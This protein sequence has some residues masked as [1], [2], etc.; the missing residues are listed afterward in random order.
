MITKEKVLEAQK[1]W[2]DGIIEIGKGNREASEFVRKMYV[3]QALFKPTMAKKE[4]FRI[5]IEKAISYFVG[6]CCEE[7]N[8]FA[9]RPWVKIRFENCGVIINEHQAL[10]MGHYFFTDK[11][12]EETIVE[13]SFG[14]INENEVIKINLHHSSLPCP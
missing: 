6:G 2:A 3:K 14:Y 13:Y 10:A 12:G 11:N 9:L 5:T 7:D 8:G 4:P 1:L